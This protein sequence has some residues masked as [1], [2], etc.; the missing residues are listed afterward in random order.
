MVSIPYGAIKRMN[1]KEKASE[2][3]MFQFLTVRL[4]ENFKETE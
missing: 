3:Q 1:K 4:K 2:T